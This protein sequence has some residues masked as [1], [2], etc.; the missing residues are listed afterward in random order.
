MLR[1]EVEQG[2]IPSASWCVQSCGVVVSS[3][4]L[5]Y[6][7]LE[8]RRIEAAT[9]TIYDLA[10]L[11]K[12]L[13]TTTLVLLAVAEGR[14]RLDDRVAEF[15]PELAARVD[16]AETTWADLL[17]HRAGF[18]AWYPLYVEGGDQDGYLRALLSRP[19]AYPPRES[20]VYSDLGFVLA[21]LALERLLGDELSA[22]AH[23]RL[24][25]PLGLSDCQFNPPADLLSRIAATERSNEKEQDMV[26]SRG[27]TFTAWREGIIWGEVNDCN[28]W[29]LGGVAGNAGLFGD[30]AGVARLASIYLGESLLPDSLR[31][32]AIECQAEGPGERRGLG[33][34]LR[35]GAAHPAAPL[36]EASFGHTGFTGT[37]VWIDP[38]A[39]LVVVLL[40]NRIH[41]R[42]R[43]SRIQQI[44]RNLNEIVA[45]IN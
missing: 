36:S 4:A 29:H 37:S 45:A 2:E 25:V 13:V 33:W 3:G 39:G 22:L 7:V 14:I 31:V 28:A 17:A 9:D 18:E 16:L 34:Q 41:P 32:R 6:S 40:T 11:T 8:P 21:S 27:L 24:F 35:V 1:V 5:G 20:V 10:S 44:R 26:R 42:V 19:L 43:D 23:R 12:P 38:N 15:V 30:A